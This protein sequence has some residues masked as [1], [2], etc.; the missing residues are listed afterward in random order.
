M[1]RFWGRCIG[2][3]WGWNHCTV[4]PHPIWGGGLWGHY[5]DVVMELPCHKSPCSGFGIVGHL[6]LSYR[7]MRSPLSSSVRGRMKPRSS[8]HCKEEEEEEEEEE[9]D[10]GHHPYEAPNTPPP[11]TQTPRNH[12]MRSALPSPHH[13]IL[14]LSTAFFPALNSLF[15]QRGG[16]HRWGG[17]CCAGDPHPHPLAASHRAAP[18]AAPGPPPPSSYGPAHTGGALGG[19][20]GGS[21]SQCRHQNRGSAGRV[22][23]GRSHLERGHGAI[24]G[25]MGMGSRILF[26]LPFLQIFFFFP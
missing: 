19:L 23:W 1:E 17:G 16:R 2:S 20:W 24:N 8:R 4:S 22:P 18:G 9:E 15:G 6:P 3:P 11:N 21:P 5:G 25:G 10:E 14:G 13:I 7:P 26:L 12:P